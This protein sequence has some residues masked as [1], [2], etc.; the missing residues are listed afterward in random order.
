MQVRQ[1]TF[2]FYR[3]NCGDHVAMA[4]NHMKYRGKLNHSDASVMLNFIIRGHYVRWMDILKLY[5]PFLLCVGIILAIL[6]L[7]KVI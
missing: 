2:K 4:L 1:F 3:N 6:A 5:F 7:G